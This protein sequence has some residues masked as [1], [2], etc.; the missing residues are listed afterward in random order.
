MKKHLALLMVLLICILSANVA[1]ATPFDTALA[2][3]GMDIT[4]TENSTGLITAQFEMVGPLTN[5]TNFKTQIFF[6]N[7]KLNLLDV[8]KTK[9]EESV[10]STTLNSAAKLAEYVE[11]PTDMKSSSWGMNSSSITIKG[12]PGTNNI[13]QFG[14]QTSIDG[15]AKWSL[16][17]ADD[18]KIIAKVYFQR[19]FNTVDAMSTT[20]TTFIEVKNSNT[21][22]YSAGTSSVFNAQG[23]NFAVKY[24]NHTISKTALATALTN[25]NTD[26]T[27]AVPGT[28]NGNYPQLAI[29]NLATAITAAQT[30]HDKASTNQLQIDKALTDLNAAVVTFKAAVIAGTETPGYDD[31]DPETTSLGANTTVAALDDNKY[32]FN[33]TVFEL[34]TTI[35]CGLEL[36]T[37][38]GKVY[39]FPAMTALKSE[40]GEAMKGGKFAVVIKNFDKVAKAGAYK[41]K[42]YYIDS[43][44]VDADT[45]PEGIDYLDGGNSTTV[46]K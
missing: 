39:K 20:N 41:F 23:A 24:T 6:D 13:I 9:V 43:T 21:T 2:G 44:L 30:A 15:S 8:S 42:A 22:A 46:T 37:P 17:T 33:G 5:F 10:N 29:D 34:P 14:L 40:G 3:A 11:L 27:A 18:K 1:F 38:T 35:E 36:T 16:E 26:K 4:F 31:T 12:T 19:L 28:A 32:T 45:N 25:A 7:S